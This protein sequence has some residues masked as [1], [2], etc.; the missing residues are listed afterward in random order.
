MDIE[1]NRTEPTYR[2]EAMSAEEVDSFLDEMFA[3]MFDSD[4][5]TSDTDR[6]PDLGGFP[7]EG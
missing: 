1:M 3:E 7:P 4:A 2:Y 6:V 5:I